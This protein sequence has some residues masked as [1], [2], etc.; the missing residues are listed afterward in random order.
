MIL[1]SSTLLAKEYYDGCVHYAKY[2]PHKKKAIDKVK[3]A[4]ADLDHLAV[5]IEAYRLNNGF[6]PKEKD[7]LIV[8]LNDKLIKSKKSLYDPW[9]RL[10][11]YKSVG[12]DFKIMTLGADGKVGGVGENKD[13]S[14]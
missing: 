4:K 11:I 8:L 2:T 1:I 3:K 13:L 5:A 7:G 10:Y 14:Y 6:Y 9:G 12:G